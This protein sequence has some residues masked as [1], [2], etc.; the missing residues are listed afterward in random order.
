MSDLTVEKIEQLLQTA[1]KRQTEELRQNLK[2]VIE[3]VTQKLKKTDEKLLKLETRSIFFERKIRKNNIVVFGI[4]V[5]ENLLDNT[6]TKINELLG[7]NLVEADINNIYTLGKKPGSPVIIEFISFL[8]KAE[9]FKNREKLRDLKGTNISIANDLCE[10]DRRNEKILRKHL[11]EAIQKNIPAKLKGY[12]LEIDGKLYSVSDLE[13]AASDSHPSSDESDC[14]STDD[15]GA[16]EE[17][18]SRESG[19]ETST[20]L[21]NKKNKEKRHTHTPS[22]RK[23]INTRQRSKKKKTR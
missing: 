12:K 4:E 7:T 1:N 6:L 19:V 16:V 18:K 2:D 22:P 8:K 13:D 14:E 10:E 17:V 11:K 23:S 15:D 20:A 5:Q 9:I 3:D 21:D